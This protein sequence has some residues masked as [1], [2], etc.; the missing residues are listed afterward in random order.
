MKLR[1]KESKNKKKKGE[2]DEEFE[3]SKKL[4]YIVPYK[5]AEFQNFMLIID[6]SFS[7]FVSFLLFSLPSL[8][9]FLLFYF[10]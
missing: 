10:T 6:I 7:F 3:L 5:E 8:L 1:N 4:I 2:T 9:L